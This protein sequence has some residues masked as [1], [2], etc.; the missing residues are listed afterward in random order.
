MPLIDYIDKETSELFKMVDKVFYPPEEKKSSPPQ[1]PIKKTMSMLFQEASELLNDLPIENKV[2]L[3]KST[4][5][6]AS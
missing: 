5:E 3:K 2:E 4:I 1:S 6:M